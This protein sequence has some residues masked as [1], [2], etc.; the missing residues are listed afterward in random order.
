[1]QTL[2]LNLYLKNINIKFLF[3]VH[4]IEPKQRRKI[5]G[6]N[7]PLRN[8]LNLLQHGY[9]NNPLNVELNYMLIEGLNDRIRDAKAL[10][11]MVNRIGNGNNCLI[12][13]N[14]FNPIPDCD[15]RP[16]SNVKRFI[17]TLQNYKICFELHETDGTDINA[18]CGQLIGG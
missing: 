3:S 2:S 11:D 4:A 15:F 10:A 18:A 5:F 17:D 9:S 6:F 8:I 16:S 12:K 7:P 1:M 14:R 13:L